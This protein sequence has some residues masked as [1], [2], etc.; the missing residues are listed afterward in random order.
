MTPRTT[1]I[2]PAL[3]PEKLLEKYI[4]Q[5]LVVA[6]AEYELALRYF[7]FVGPYRLKGYLHH[8]IDSQ[9]KQLTD[10]LSFDT[11]RQYYEF[12]RELR[13]LVIGA[14]DRIE[15]AVRTSM[16]N[17]LSL[18]HGAH[19]FLNPSIFNETREWSHEKLVKTLTQDTSKAHNRQFVSHYF[20]H[21]ESPDLPP[22]WAISEIVSFGFWS[23]TYSVL[24]QSNDRKAI[25][26]KFKIDQPE[27]FR[28]WLHALTVLRNHAAHHSQILYA[29]I[30]VKPS[31]YKR[32]DIHFTAPE[33]FESL[34]IILEYFLS[35]I[36][37]GESWDIQLSQLFVRYPA[38]SNQDLMKY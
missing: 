24:N 21:Y 35:Q 19:W 30:R 23:K 34:S 37:L 22:S 14:I 3:T 20:K 8:R 32:K 26:M 4:Q 12:D 2:K 17:V 36:A 15:V 10:E 25:A 9:T 28:S 1:F 29:P 38:V 11:L 6:E 16:S 5:G 33:S 7:R 18:K 13:L 27:V 31:H